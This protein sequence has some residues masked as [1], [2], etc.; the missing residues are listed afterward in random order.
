MNYL[1]NINS[2]MFWALS[3][4]TL[5]LIHSSFWMA[6]SSISW[7]FSYPLEIMYSQSTR[8]SGAHLK[9]FSSFITSLFIMIILINFMGLLPYT[10][11]FSSHLIFTLSLGFPLWLSLILSSASHNPKSFTASLLPG[12]APDWLNPF[13]VLIET[14]SIM[15]RPITLSVRLAANMSAGHIVLGLIGIYASSAMFSSIYSASMLISIQ[16]LYTLFEMGICLIQA[17]IFCLLITLY[18]D[19]HS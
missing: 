9:S 17:Y 15:V 10:F 1:T 14:I 12:G 13:L 6:P 18:A 4:T 16:I 5:L 11:S 8:T 7:V 19:D 3:F 2:P